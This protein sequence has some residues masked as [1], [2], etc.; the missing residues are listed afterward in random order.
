M[1]I[2]LPYG[3]EHFSVD[4]EDARVNAVLLS[5]LEH[6]VPEKTQEQLVE[7][8]LMNPIGTEKLS[9]LARGKK[10][11]VIIASDHTR[12]VPSKIIMPLMLKE[13]R[14]YNPDVDITI[15]IATG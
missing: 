5:D 3:K 11:V 6:Y 7:D 9:E 4:I 10:K 2:S 1:N 15:L 13:I 12:P 14:K 8:A